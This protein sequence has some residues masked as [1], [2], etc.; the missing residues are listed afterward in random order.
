MTKNLNTAD[1]FAKLA[2]S[3]FTILSYF[4]EMITGPFAELLAI[5]SFVVLIIYAIKLVVREEG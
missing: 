5:L 1:L 2:L 4:L 3:V